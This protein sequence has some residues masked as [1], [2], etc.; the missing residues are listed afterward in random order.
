VIEREAAAAAA[1]ASG[2][3]P[4][5]Y[6]LDL[7]RNPRMKGSRRDW[8]AA[9][10]LPYVHPKLVSVEG[11]PDKPI[12]HEHRLE[13]LPLA[14]A[15]AYILF[16]GVAKLEPESRVIEHKGKDKTPA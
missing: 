16:K 14:R 4:L 13:D 10:A 7:M 12:M 8:A 6:V 5:Q 2:I 11:N 9:Q 1:A 15:V 3:T